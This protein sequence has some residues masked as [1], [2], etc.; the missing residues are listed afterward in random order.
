MDRSAAYGSRFSVDAIASAHCRTSLPRMPW[1]PLMSMTTRGAPIRGH[2]S[3]VFSTM[4]ST[5]RTVSCLRRANLQTE[6]REIVAGIF[7]WTPRSI[8]ARQKVVAVPEDIGARRESASVSC[9]K[10]TRRTPRCCRRRR[11]QGF[12]YIARAS[13]PANGIVV[14]GHRVL[15]PQEKAVQQSAQAGSRSIADRAAAARTPLTLSEIAHRRPSPPSCSSAAWSSRGCKGGATFRSR[16]CPT[17]SFGYSNLRVVAMAPRTR[18]KFR[19]DPIERSWRRIPA[20]TPSR[21][22]R[23]LR[24]SPFSFS[25]TGYR[26]G[27]A[28]TCQSVPVCGAAALAAR[29]AEPPSF[30]SE[31]ADQPC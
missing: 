22:L 15:S 21:R 24:R 18:C 9:R 19:C 16:R 26:C 27:S 12:E 5:R 4:R 31:T 29:N 30:R 14:D 11:G 17:S 25:L 10:S 3:N 2:A 28:P 8:S 23:E 13:R 1:S 7:W 20:S 6:D